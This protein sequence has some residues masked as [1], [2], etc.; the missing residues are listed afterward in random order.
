MF[1]IPITLEVSDMD[2]FEV[3]D[4]SEVVS[5][6]SRKPKYSTKVW[7]YDTP[8]GEARYM[9]ALAR[10]HERRGSEYAEDLRQKVDARFEYEIELES[11]LPI[12]ECDDSSKSSSRSSSRNFDYCESLNSILNIHFSSEVHV[13]SAFWFDDSCNS[14]FCNVPA[15]VV[16][17]KITL[18]DLIE[19]VKDL[20]AS[21]KFDKLSNDRKNLLFDWLDAAYKFTSMVKDDHYV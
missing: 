14:A 5:F 2:D 16:Y 10:L 9:L 17:S 12:Y 18:D 13:L 8:K 7:E 20:I 19:R 11:V 21:N 3:I 4:S 1:V 6:R 15:G